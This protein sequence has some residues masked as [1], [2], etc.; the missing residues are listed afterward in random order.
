MRQRYL[1][2][3]KKEPNA[4]NRWVASVL[5][6]M[7]EPLKEVCC[8]TDWGGSDATRIAG[9]MLSASLHPIDRFFMQLRRRIS[10]LERPIASASSGHRTWYGYSSY[11]PE[12]VQRIMGLF[13]VI[14]NYSL[15]GKDGKT[16]A[17]RLG[18][19][20]RPIGHNEILAFV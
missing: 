17:M 2:I 6:N 9:G 16:P 10:L 12:V 8:L 5:P 18:L 4:A 20:D 11:N 13:R 15:V 1:E 14:Y 7:G 3:R 19:A